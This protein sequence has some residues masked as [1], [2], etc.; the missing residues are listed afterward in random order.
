MR[1]QN[2]NT[3]LDFHEVSGELQNRRRKLD[4]LYVIKKT[5]LFSPNEMTWNISLLT[6]LPSARVP[7]TLICVFCYKDTL[8]S[9]FQ[10]V[11]QKEHKGRFW[12]KK[13]LNSLNKCKLFIEH[14]HPSN[15]CRKNVTLLSTFKML[16]APSEQRSVKHRL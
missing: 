3:Y 16:Q 7:S 1:L 2:I 10:W 6:S 14:I 15:L 4:A 12:R 8:F 5:Q 13:A 9:I 11:Y